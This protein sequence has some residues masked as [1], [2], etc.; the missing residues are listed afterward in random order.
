[1]TAPA[2]IHRP[3]EVLRDLPI[4]PEN[5][6]NLIWCLLRKPDLLRDDS[7]S[8]S[9]E[10]FHFG[11]HKRI[12]QAMADLDAEGILPDPGMISNRLSDSSDRDY[13]LDLTETMW[14]SPLNAKFYAEKLREV[15]IKRQALFDAE[16]LHRA[17][18]PEDIARVR[19]EIGKREYPEQTGKTIWV[20]A[21]DICQQP[22]SSVEWLV[23]RIF[24]RSGAGTVDG[25]PESGKSSLIVNLA[26]TI[27]NSGGCWFGQEC[28][29]GPVVVL[30]GEKSSR[31]VWR[32][33]FERLGKVTRPGSFLIPELDGPLW[34]WDRREG[35]WIKTPSYAEAIRG[36][37][38]IKPVLVIGDTIMRLG[39]GIDQIDNAQQAALGLELE[40]LAA[41]SGCLFLTIGHTNQ[42]STKEA[43]SWRLH[44][45]SRAGGNGLPGVLRYCF[46]V[47]RIHRCD[48]GKNGEIEGMFSLDEVSLRKLVACGVSKGNEIPTAAWTNNNPAF[49]EIMP[50]GQIMMLDR[51]RFVSDKPM[52][53][54]RAGCLKY[55]EHAGGGYHD[56]LEDL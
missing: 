4:D 1:M 54:D 50:S 19:A 26:A 45:L 5:E 41:E 49:F 23:D 29:S 16:K 30:G 9:V 20:D 47:T 15:A 18:S 44:Y 22:L 53:V 40:E 37:K 35:V 7:L 38:R 52:V 14:A 33:D 32:R 43:L 12:V 36:I 13:L 17:D 24:P 8:F 56:P 48:V 2:K 39:L 6:K 10:D 31:A 3:V 51:D 11:P 25:P 28:L 46:A 21:F 55:P 42:A 27:A 34:K